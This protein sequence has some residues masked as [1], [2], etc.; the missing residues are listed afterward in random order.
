MLKWIAVIVCIGLLAAAFLRRKGQFLQEKMMK[1]F[2]KE[3]A[4]QAR[5]PVG[6]P[7]GDYENLY[8][9]LTGRTNGPDGE[10][11]ETIPKEAQHLFIAS[12]LD[13]E[14]QNGGL[15]QFF[16]NYGPAYAKRAEESLR[17][18]GFEKIADAYKRFVAE[19]GIDLT[20]LHEFRAE[21]A[22]QFSALYG[23]YPYDA[24]DDEYMKLRRTLE[25][26]ERILEYANTHP[27]AFQ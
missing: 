8:L 4:R 10:E 6:P 25:F 21:T 5:Q 1:S 16:V 22:E 27:E 9:A 23:L 18:V 2:L 19:Q 15:C 3:M 20:A 13:M 24:F 17:A 26:E 14:I 11:F 12:V 7:F